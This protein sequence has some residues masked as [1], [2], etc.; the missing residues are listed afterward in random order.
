M[1]ERVLVCILAQT[2]AHQLTWANFEKNVLGELNA[3]LAVCIGV[4]QQ[5]DYDNPY[6]KNARFRCIIPESAD[7]AAE[8]DRI[9][10]SLG[11]RT[12]WRG[13]LK[14]CEDYYSIF[15]GGVAGVAGAG[16]ILLVYRWYLR[17]YIAEQQLDA[18][19]DRFIITRSD[20]IYAAPHPCLDAIER[21]SIW[22]P[23]GED[24]GGLVD[25]HMVVNNDDVIKSLSTL[26]DLLR[27]PEDWA[28]ALA[29]RI[30]PYRNIEGVLE[31][32]FKREGL[33]S[34]VR[35]F[36]YIMYLV[37]G[38]NDPTRWTEGEFDPELGLYV[39]YPTELELA[40]QWKDRFRSQRDWLEWA[41]QPPA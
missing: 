3:D 20:F 19:Y 4:D 27:N 15:L 34:R 7:Y 30:A 36:P 37:R 24:W 40:N 33:F 9:S 29:A 28:A 13:L 11:H 32:Y 41:A 25:R 38:E 14:L 8:I 31:I 6:F 22:L 35:R 26:S 21:G 39:K 18:R 17:N 10:V 16:A 1:S 23:D 5:Y 2:R 12:D